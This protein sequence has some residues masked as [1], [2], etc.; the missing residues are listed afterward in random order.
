MPACY[1]Q[2][3]WV[4]WMK[5]QRSLMRQGCKRNIIITLTGRC[6]VSYHLERHKQLRKPYD[7]RC[8]R[9]WPSSI[10]PLYDIPDRV[11]TRGSSES[12]HWCFR[13]TWTELN[14]IGKQSI[15]SQILQM[16]RKDNAYFV[17]PVPSRLCF[18][19]KKI[20][21]VINIG[22]RNTIKAKSWLDLSPK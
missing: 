7:N 11:R 16:K 2:T 4:V 9:R 10:S 14:K 13:P 20:R 15:R 17:K 1:S 6:R 18:D 3:Q 12:R 8:C 21:A 22:V 19:V 5:N